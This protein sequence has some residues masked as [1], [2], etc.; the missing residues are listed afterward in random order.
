MGE[1]LLEKILARLEAIETRLAGQTIMATLGE[2]VNNDIPVVV[3]NNTPV[4]LTVVASEPEVTID[5]DGCPWDERINT[6]TKTT[7][8]KGIYTRKKGLDDAFYDQVRNEI[9][10]SATPTDTVAPTAPTIPVTPGVPTTPT[11]PVTPVTPS[12]AENLKAE[13][14]KACNTLTK[15]YGVNYDDILAILSGLGATSFADLAVEKYGEFMTEMQSWESKLKIIKDCFDELKT[16]T[17]GSEYEANISSAV[18]QW[19]A[20]GGGAD[21]IV[22][23]IKQDKLMSIVDQVTAWADQWDA[24]LTPAG[25]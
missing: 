24:V 22:G 17:A 9:R 23:S 16:R 3:E 15:D 2:T 10:V 12:P 6:A 11:I 7:T 1:G 20:N 8:A 18:V 19:V 4:T 14:I 5:K 21:G 25:K 13:A